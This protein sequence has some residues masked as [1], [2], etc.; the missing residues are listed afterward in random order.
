MLQTNNGVLPVELGINLLCYNLCGD[1]AVPLGAP[2]FNIEVTS[3]NGDS[4][5]E[6][7]LR[8]TAYE[9]ASAGCHNR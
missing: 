8:L 6:S 4:T 3:F 7:E 1:P 5:G 9:K 2:D